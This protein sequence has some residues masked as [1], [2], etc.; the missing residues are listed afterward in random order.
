[1]KRLRLRGSW[2]LDT[3]S[4]DTVDPRMMNRSTPASTTYRQ[5]FWVRWG[6]SFAATTTP[7]SRSCRKRAVMSDGLIG[8]E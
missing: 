3:C 4:A 1:M 6:E 7:A 8:S 2:W 5:Y